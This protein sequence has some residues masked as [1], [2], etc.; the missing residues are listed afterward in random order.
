MRHPRPDPA[1]Q[2]AHPQPPIPA[3]SVGRCSR[4]S[5]TKVLAL[6]PRTGRASAHAPGARTAHQSG[7]HGRAGVGHSVLARPGARRG[8]LG[9]GDPGASRGPARADARVSRLRPEPCPRASRANID[10]AAT[11]LHHSLHQANQLDPIPIV[12][13]DYGGL[14]APVLRGA[15]SQPRP[16][17]GPPRVGR[18]CPRRAQPLDGARANQNA[19]MG[20]RCRQALAD[21]RPGRRVGRRTPVVDVRGGGGSPPP[22]WSAGCLRAMIGAE[23]LEASRTI[24][25]PILVLRGDA[26]PLR[27]R[28]RRGHPHRPCDQC[29]PG[30]CCAR[31]PLAA[32]GGAR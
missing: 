31:G 19:R 30:Q 12:A 29:H 26:D 4:S 8:R 14:V 32:P 18:V 16:A 10:Q 23:Y 9:V 24:R 25:A 1:P 17:P 21:A 11:L 13:H 22:A 3:H 28:G 7:N 20:C 27:H 2:H 15:I 6:A 5:R